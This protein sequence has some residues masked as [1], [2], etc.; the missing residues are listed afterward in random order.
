MSR[1]A[2][3][4]IKLDQ[5][6]KLTQLA[7]SGGHAKGLIQSG[8]VQVNGEVEIRRGRKLFAGDRVTFEDHSL[9]VSLDDPLNLT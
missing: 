8:M 2:E 6:L 5:F 4:H 1:S 7:P 3:P 9:E